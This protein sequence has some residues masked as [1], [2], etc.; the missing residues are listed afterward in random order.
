MTLLKIIYF[1]T[2]TIGAAIII[3]SYSLNYSTIFL[4]YSHSSLL[5]SKISSLSSGA[6]RA[7]TLLAVKGGS[8]SSPTSLIV[9]SAS[10]ILFL[11]SAIKF[12]AIFRLVESEPKLIKYYF[13]YI[14]KYP[15]D[16]NLQTEPFFHF[17]RFLFFRIFQNLLADIGRNFQ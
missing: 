12:S 9:T 3:V 16:Q 4:L 5:S 17:R 1:L 15:W 8:S 14:R 6:N 7:Q 2:N 13:I 11:Y 10:G